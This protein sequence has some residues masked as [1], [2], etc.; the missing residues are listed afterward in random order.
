MYFDQ[1][2]RVEGSVEEREAKMKKESTER[3][4]HKL[5]SSSPLNPLLPVASPPEKSRAALELRERLRSARHPSKDTPWR[6]E[7]VKFGSTLNNRVFCP[8]N[9]DHLNP[10]VEEHK[11]A[12]HRI[13]IPRCEEPPFYYLHSG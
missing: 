12:C 7:S 1:T 9:P 3:V 11:K 10:R 8:N 6:E 5:S 4:I 13:R 2:K